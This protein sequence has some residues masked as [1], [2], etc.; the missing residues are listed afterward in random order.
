MAYH[1]GAQIQVKEGKTMTQ[2]QKNTIE[3]LRATGMQYAEIASEM[4]MSLSTIKM[5]FHRKK[6]PAP[7]RCDQCHRPLI[8]TNKKARFCSASCRCK[9]HQSHLDV[10]SDP[11]KYIRYCHVCGR[12]FYSTKNASFCSRPCYYQSRRKVAVDH[13]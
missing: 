9:W 5:Y 12:M 6:K 13:E 11:E 2:S 10:S 8:T 7:P 1:R 3:T 4:G